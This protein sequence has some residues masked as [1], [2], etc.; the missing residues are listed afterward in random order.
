MSK[1]D[2]LGLVAD[3]ETCIEKARKYLV[4]TVNEAWKA[5]YTLGLPITGAAVER[6]LKPMSSVPTKVSSLLN[7][8]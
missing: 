6:L 2:K 8:N 3:M 5:I 1:T 7:Q 4:D